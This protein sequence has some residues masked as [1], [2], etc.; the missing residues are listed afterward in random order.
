MKEVSLSPR[1]LTS[2]S[3]MMSASTA[4]DLR[5]ASLAEARTSFW[6]AR[7]SSSSLWSSFAWPCEGNRT[8][9]SFLDKMCLKQNNHMTKGA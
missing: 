7:E 1:G 3:W 6:A 4:L 9:G 5:S 2:C 8:F